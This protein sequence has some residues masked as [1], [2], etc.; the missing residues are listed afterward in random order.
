MSLGVGD[1]L[2]GA[3][4]RMTTMDPGFLQVTGN[5]ARDL[6]ASQRL[7]GTVRRIQSVD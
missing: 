1:Y 3:K 7:Q 2:L 6:W 5:Q 4:L